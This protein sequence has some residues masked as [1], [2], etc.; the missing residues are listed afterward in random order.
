MPVHELVQATV[1][2]LMDQMAGKAQPQS[3]VITPS[4]IIRSSS[5]PCPQRN[6]S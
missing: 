2:E 3:Q 4:L 5:G 6:G 1:D